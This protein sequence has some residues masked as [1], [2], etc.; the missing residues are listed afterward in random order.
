MFG[1]SSELASV[2]EFGFET[3]RVWK[4]DPLKTRVLCSEPTTSR[5]VVVI[6]QMGQQIWMS[7]WVTWVVGH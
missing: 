5:W 7:G 3:S 2:M 4:L 1:A 6:G